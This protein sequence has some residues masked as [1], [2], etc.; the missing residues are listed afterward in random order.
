MSLSSYIGAERGRCAELARHLDIA[1]AWVSQMAAG[2]R[3]VPAQHC[4][5]IEH[6]SGGAVRVWDLR[7]DDWHLI[8]PEMIGA[9]GAPSVNAD[10]PAHVANAA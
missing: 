1:P 9:E 4:R 8:W 10:E 7:P 3:P 2:K 5:P 6:W